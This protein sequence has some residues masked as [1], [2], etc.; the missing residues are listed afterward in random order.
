[1]P[2]GTQKVPTGGDGSTVAVR[3]VSTASLER[4]VGARAIDCGIAALVL[5]PLAALT[6][7]NGPN[8]S[9]R[10]QLWPWWFV[11]AAY[12]LPVSYEAVCLSW[13]SQT[14]GKHLLGLEL[15]HGKGQPLRP[16][17]ALVRAAMSWVFVVY[18]LTE[19]MTPD[20]FIIWLLVQVVIFAPAIFLPSHRGLHDMAAGSLVAETPGRRHLPRLTGSGLPPV[21]HVTAVRLTQTPGRSKLMKVLCLY[22]L[23]ARRL[24]LVGGSAGREARHGNSH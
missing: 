21:S 6:G 2:S 10:L 3:P 11:L 9:D 8:P 7:R 5:V 15:T 19:Y 4:R 12:L 22:P 13:R 14:I 20:V 18:V 1:M 17:S 23:P 24:R 16:L